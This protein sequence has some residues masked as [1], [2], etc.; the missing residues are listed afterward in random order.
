MTK[1]KST[2]NDTSSRK[3]N[4][5][6]AAK[7]TLN[8]FSPLVS[9]WWS[10][11]KTKIGPNWSVIIVLISILSF[12][13]GHILSGLLF[14]FVAAPIAM[15]IYRYARPDTIFT[16]GSL[17]KA[18]FAYDVVYPCIAL[19][20]AW[21]FT[22]GFGSAQKEQEEL[23]PNYEF[24]CSEEGIK[25]SGKAGCQRAKDKLIEH[26][27]KQLTFAQEHY[28]E[29][30]RLAEQYTKEKNQKC[31][32]KGLIEY[33]SDGCQQATK[34]S[35]SHTNLKNKYQQE[36]DTLKQKINEIKK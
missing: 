17:L 3:E 28:Q 35:E 14:M 11:M 18:K 10:F 6:K 31:T 27:Q 34:N 21:F 9:G 19:G 1:E 2:T 33:G 24:A 4:I 5:Q 23:Q 29:E 15:L 7:K 12:C 25:K 22:V 20:L 16:T 30:N 36:V 32:E 13:Q 8:S 26:L